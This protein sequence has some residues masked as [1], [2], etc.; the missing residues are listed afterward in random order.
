MTKDWTPKDSE[1]LY[2]LKGWGLNYFQVNDAGH[3]SFQPLRNVKRSIDVKRVVDDVVSRGVKLPALIRFQDI[4]RDRVAV[5]NRAFKRAI[6]EYGYAGRYFGVYPIKVNQLREVVEEVLDAGKPFQLGLEAGSKP[7]LMAVLAMNSN[8]ALAI[9][10]GYKD[11]AMMRLACV[12]TKIG[13]RIVVVIEKLSEL[14]MLLDAAEETGMRPNVGLRAKLETEGSGK[15]ATSAG[16]GAKFGLTTSEII[17]AVRKLEA[18]GMLD[19]AKLLHFHIGSQVTDI[20]VVKEAVKEG[21]RVYAK[22]RGMGAELEFLDCGGGLGVD[23]EG[24]KTSSDHSMNYT[25]EEYTRD[26]VY[27]VQEVCAEE[28]VPEPNIVTESGRALTAHHAILV[29]D[30]FGSIEASSTPIPVEET[31]TEHKVVRD[32]RD[33]LKMLNV[34]NLAESYHDA[35]QALQEAST[36]FRLGFLG[37]EDKAKAETLYWRL[38]VE[39]AK[40]IPSAE[41]VP[42]DVAAMVQTLHDQYLVNFSVFQSLPDIWAIEQIFPIMPLHRLCEEPERRASIADIT[43]DSDGKVSTFASARGDESTL[44]LHALNGNPYYLGIFLMG[45]YQATMGDIHNLFGRV[46]EV[47]VFQDEEEPGGYYLEEIIRGQRVWDVLESIQYNKFELVKMVKAAI[48]QRVKAGALKP[49][50]G[51]D[52]L[53]F[54][55]TMMREYTYIER[56]GAAREPADFQHGDDRSVA[57]SR[58]D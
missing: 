47:H 13:R 22:L 29:V 37:L 11:M 10:N 1:K 16:H 3:L 23:Y 15:W 9:V 50:E 51:V 12:G 39:V 30:A 4:L 28:K 44:P 24:A 2:N 54:Y 45:A 57:S 8:D 32:I 55:E 36:M 52:L 33:A 14:D 43:C 6:K 25:L 49:R 34:E 20:R 17:A 26:V 40:L 56:N 58:S 27:A 53:N 18:R 46:N 31:P 41:T 48:D 5:L 7:E 35:Q 19:C 21:A 42:E 38:C